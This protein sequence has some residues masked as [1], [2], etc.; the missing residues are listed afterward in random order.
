MENKVAVDLE[1]YIDLRQE[2]E[3]LEN[4]LDLIFAE[5]RYSKVLNEDKLYFKSDISLMSYLKIVESYKYNAR[6]EELKKEEE[7]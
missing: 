3:E 2:S 4:I 1:E 6:L 5:S 7:G